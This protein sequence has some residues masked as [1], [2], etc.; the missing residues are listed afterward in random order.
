MPTEEKPEK[1]PSCEY[2]VKDGAGNEQPCGSEERIYQVSAPAK[3]MWGNPY[4]RDQKVC[5]RHLGD[6]W[7]GVPT[8]T[9]AMPIDV[10]THKGASRL[11]GSVR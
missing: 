1:R 2:P 10:P 6:A 7:K 5:Q 4:T 11:N 3:D 9:T 8:D